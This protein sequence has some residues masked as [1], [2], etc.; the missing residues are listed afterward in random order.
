MRRAPTLALVAAALAPS[1]AR[2][3]PSPGLDVTR[4]KIFDLAG[5]RKAIAAELAVAPELQERLADVRITIECPDAITARVSVVPAPPDA[6][7]EKTL[8]LGDLPGDLRLRLV[9][10]AVAELVDV[11]V[12]VEPPPD[13]GAAPPPPPPPSVRT[14]EGGLDARP[15]E[16]AAPPAPPGSTVATAVELRRDRPALG[17]R[18]ALTGAD[19]AGDQLGLLAG[20]RVFL[21][22]GEPL[23]EL[24]GEVSRGPFALDL[25]AATGTSDDSLGELRALV[26]GA[27][28]SARLG[29][30]GSAG[31]WL[32]AAVRAAG[33]VAAVG[34]D[35]VHPMIESEG[36]TAPYLELG[37][38]L[39]VR[40][41]SARWTGA[42]LL[43]AGWSSGL[44]A[45][46]EQRA[47]VRLAGPFITLSLGVGR[48]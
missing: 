33:G 38:R 20:V 29:C 44:V 23:V 27:G 31:T 24:A 43:G 19:P 9:A 21:D 37:P 41:E 14:G 1:S 22:Q 39:E 32:C 12:T 30:R 17:R 45:L 2:A 40:V 47:V 16:A 7:L 15:F 28:A 13:P 3:D 18:R 26:A 11:A 48:R 42:L 35:P 8:D 5:A 46:A 6:P 10:L 4:C 25:F 36:A 34:A